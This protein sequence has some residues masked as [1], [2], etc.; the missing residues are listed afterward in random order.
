MSLYSSKVPGFLTSQVIGQ[1]RTTT[2]PTP[3]LYS[4]C[5]FVRVRYVSS[6]K[7]SFHQFAHRVR[8]V[9]KVKKR[10]QDDLLLS[11]KKTLQ[12]TG[13]KTCLLTSC[14]ND[15]FA[16]F[17]VDCRESKYAL[18]KIRISSLHK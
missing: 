18:S 9:H 15:T 4:L 6:R 13:N 8:S 14:C 7:N 3:R 10:R 1:G 2:S 5:K 11:Y 12:L 17:P 16:T